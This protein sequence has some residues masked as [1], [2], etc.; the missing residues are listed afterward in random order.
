MEKGQFFNDDRLRWW[1][2]ALKKSAGYHISNLLT[3]CEEIVAQ[4][5]FIGNHIGSENTTVLWGHR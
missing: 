1:V 2:I 4:E 5:Q 3:L